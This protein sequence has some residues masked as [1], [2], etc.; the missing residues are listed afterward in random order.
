MGTYALGIDLGGTSIKGA[1]VERTQ[2]IVDRR[3]RPTEGEQGPEHVLDRIAAVAREL[4]RAHSDVTPVG[5]GMGVPGAVDLERTTVHY[6]SNLADWR[7]VNVREALSAR[8]GIHHVVVENDAN[9]AGL[10][11]A[12]YGAGIAHDSFIMVT[13][14]TGVGG[15]IIY[16]NK[17]FRGS[18][19]GAGEIGHVSI[20]YE[21]PLDNSGVSGA[22]EAYLGQHF[23]SEHARIRLRHRPASAVHTL[24]DGDLSTLTPRILHEAATQGDEAAIEVLAWAGRKLGYALSS[25]ISLLDIR[26][27][28]VGGGVSKA[29]DFLLDPAREVLHHQVFPAFQ[30]GLRIERE[31][32]GN[33]VAVLGAAQL[34]F[35]TSPS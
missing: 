15:A 21:G 12:H 22:I 9:V 27:V 32:L 16:N 13:L 31:Q 28:V 11:S 29:G 23:L 6:P 3:T 18:T 10:G 8:T 2:G 17:V 1:L 7:V 34:A 20:D 4:L 35:S 5:L 26:V 33:E 25:A 24:T 30:E 19:G 14:G